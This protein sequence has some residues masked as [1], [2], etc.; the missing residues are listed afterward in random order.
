MA[1]SK[2]FMQKVLGAVANGLNVQDACAVAGISKQTLY[3]HVNSDPS[4]AEEFEKAQV[5]FKLTHLRNVA[6]AS[7]NDWRAS[8]WILERKFKDEFSLR[9]EMVGKDGADLNFQVTIVD[10]STDEQDI[11]TP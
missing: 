1:Y 9:Q 10:A 2:D 6:S 5:S 7:Q 11:P 3:N 8:A 4:F